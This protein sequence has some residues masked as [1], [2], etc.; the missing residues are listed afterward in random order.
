MFEIIKTLLLV[1]FLLITLNIYFIKTP[2]NIGLSV[3]IQTLIICLILNFNLNFY[4]LS[5]IFYLIILGGILILFIYLCSIASN[6][7]IKI[8]LNL[9][10]IY[11]LLFIFSYTVLIQ[12]NWIYPNILSLNNFN[13]FYIIENLSISKIYNNFTVFISIFLV[14]Y[15]FILLLIVTIL[16]NSNKGPLRIFSH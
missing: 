4:W 2:L 7:I 1:I 9:L 16:T 5:Y 15:L 11:V 12:Y 13:F 10:F 6:E 8:N 3:L 14:F